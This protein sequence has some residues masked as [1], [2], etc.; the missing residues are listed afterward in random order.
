MNLPKQQQQQLNE[1][2][3]H[4]PLALT[5]HPK[6][7]LQREWGKTIDAFDGVEIGLEQLLRL[8]AT[9]MILLGSHN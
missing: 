9:E 2:L 6:G 1:L 4:R 7:K 8:K 3:T 5:K